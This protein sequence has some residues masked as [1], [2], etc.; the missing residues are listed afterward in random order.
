MPLNIPACGPFWESRSNPASSLAGAESDS[1]LELCRRVR[2]LFRFWQGHPGPMTVARLAWVPLQGCG[3]PNCRLAKS[4]VK[5]SSSGEWWPVGPPDLP[6]HQYTWDLDG[7]PSAL[8]TRVH[9]EPPS[10][11]LQMR[12]WFPRCLVYVRRFIF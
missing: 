11:L 2:V 10:D 5:T 9:L 6:F 1:G 7:W 4:Q 12:S 8:S 3:P